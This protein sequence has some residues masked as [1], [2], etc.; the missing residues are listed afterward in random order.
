MTNFTANIQNLSI[1]FIEVNI[2]RPPKKKNEI[3]TGNL[4]NWIKEKKRHSKKSFTL[5]ISVCW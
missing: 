4:R 2:Q 5:K 3:K 1:A